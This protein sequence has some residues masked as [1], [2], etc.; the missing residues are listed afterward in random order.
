[1]GV[2]DYLQYS[3]KKALEKN[4]VI[5]IGDKDPQIKNNQF[6]FYAVN[7]YINDDFK[8]FATLYEHLSTNPY[9]FE[10]FCFLRWFL[11]KELMVREKID[12]S[13][14]ID[15]DVMLY[16]DV[17]NEIH[18][19]KQYDFTLLH[20]TAAISSFITISGIN[21]F[22]NL[23]LNIYSHKNSYKYE[24]IKSHFTIRQKYGLGGGVC[25]MTLLDLFHYSA[26]DGGGPG[27]VGEMMI[28]L[29]D[30]TYDHNI[31]VPDQNFDFKNGIKNIQMIDKTPYVYSNKLN[32]LI[33]FNSLHF[34]SS[35]KT[36]MVKYF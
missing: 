14:Y 26:D 34:N 29:D 22:C 18:K 9:N 12:I 3:L 8:K 33:K 30:S 25:D 7:Q 1:M 27:R 23:L 4:R 21:N 19:F 2:S 24:K 6:K 35:A 11:V 16:V 31:N 10:L 5:L 15:S 20:R 17:N 32:K 28:I 13:F 36:L